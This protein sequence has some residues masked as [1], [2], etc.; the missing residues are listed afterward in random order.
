MALRCPHALGAARAIQSTQLSLG[1]TS[2][3]LPTYIVASAICMLPGAIAYTWLGHAGRSAAIGD[4]SSLR[5]GLLGI[6]VLAMIA[7]LPRLFRGFRASQPAW[8]ESGELQRR[9]VAGDAVVLVDVRDPEEFNGPP[10]HL[11]GAVN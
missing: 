1:L 8:I 5:Y 4:T 6:G 3:S 7:F 10:G 11:P 2:V 9:L